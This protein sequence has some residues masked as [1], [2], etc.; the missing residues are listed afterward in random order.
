MSYN[1][2]ILADAPIG[3]WRLNDREG[4]T[5]IDLSGNGHHGTLTGKVGFTDT[6]LVSDDHAA[7]SALFKFEHGAG[8]RIYM[9]TMPPPRTFPG[10]MDALT[11]E[12]IYQAVGAGCGVF[13]SAPS[14]LN[15]NQIGCSNPNAGQIGAVWNKLATSTAPLTPG[16]TAHYCVVFEG[17]GVVDLYIDGVLASHVTGERCSWQWG[18]WAYDYVGFGGA[19]GAPPQFGASFNLGTNPPESYIDA[20]LEGYLAEVAIYNRRL[21]PER[22]LAHAQLAFAGAP[23]AEEMSKEN[24]GAALIASIVKDVKNPAVS[25]AQMEANVQTLID[26]Y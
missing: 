20:Y 18:K 11:V 4:T 15:S 9:E 12:F 3:Y 17:P 6:A 14:H 5:A 25:K 8:G 21:L 22:I 13:A 16:H 24:L 2:E 10:W 19:M 1:E 23:P 26:R 7:G